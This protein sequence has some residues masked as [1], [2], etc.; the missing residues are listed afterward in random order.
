MK[1]IFTNKFLPIICL[2]MLVVFT[3]FTNCFAIDVSYNDKDYTLPEFP[4][5]TTKYKY[6]AILPDNF[7]SPSSNF[8][9][10]YLY[11]FEDNK[12]INNGSITGSRSECI[13]TSESI[14]WS[15]E[16]YG[17][18]WNPMSSDQLAPIWSNFDMLDKNGNVVFQKAPQVAEITKAL[19]EQTTKAQVAQQLQN[20]IK[21]FLIY[22]VVFVVSLL[23]FWKGWRLLSNSLRKA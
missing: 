10:F 1:K 14:V 7:A 21:S 11:G 12:L 22:L 3:L 13:L 5:W 8:Y 23:A 4:S 20:T 17:T 15:A 2:F 18:T 9:S 19:V 6:L 16:S